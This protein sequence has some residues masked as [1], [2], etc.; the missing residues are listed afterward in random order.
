[1]V[2]DV[3]EKLVPAVADCHRVVWNIR[4]LIDG[5]RIL[6]I[7]VVAT[8]QYPKGLGPTLGELADRLPD[9]PAKL[10]FSCTGCPDLFKRLRAEG[11]F[12]VSAARRG[13]RRF[14]LRL[15]TF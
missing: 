8:E 1:M 6:G 13:G 4:R 12:L 9:R 11:A 7:P 14:P 10:T 2:V 15:L 5:A 3:Q